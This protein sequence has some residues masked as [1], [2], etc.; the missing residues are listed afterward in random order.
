MR[1]R[2]A[3][4]LSLGVAAAALLSARQ[5]AVPASLDKTYQRELVEKIATLL[6]SEY[7]F[8]DIGKTAAEALSKRAQ[9]GAYDT[10]RSPAEFA[11]L[12]SAELL[13]LTRDKH[14]RVRFAPDS[15][16]ERTPREMNPAMD[17]FGVRKVEWLPGKIAYLKI[18]RFYGA[19]ESRTA[20]D[21]AVTLAAPASAMVI[22]LRENGGGS[23]A[24]VLLASY[25]F[26]DRTLFNEIRWRDMDTTPFWTDPSVRPQLLQTPV[27]IL[28]SART[29]SAAEAFAYGMQRLK[30]AI[31]VGE[32]TAGGANPNRYFPLGA[33]LAVSISV[34]QT[35]NPVSKSNW[36]GV[37]VEP[38]IA[39]PAAG[40]L[41]TAIAR[42]RVD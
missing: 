7:V 32:R 16:G 31:V 40:A 4:V 19:D 26:A 37:G 1:I 39:V 6:A 11:T 22:D 33:G 27:Y 20:F 18:D 30:R 24:N 25:F 41:D 14:C 34:G 29:F 9:S 21:A 35:V 23:D 2:I 8:P 13:T 15:V 17:N 36:E 3:F 12:L 5:A 10:P 28:T 38:D 42:I